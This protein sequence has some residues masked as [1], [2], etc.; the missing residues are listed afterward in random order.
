LRSVPAGNVK[1]SLGVSVGLA[2][3]AVVGAQS[4]F[5]NAEAQ[6]VDRARVAL[7]EDEKGLSADW[8]ANGGGELGLLR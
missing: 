5:D 2:P 4:V 7:S 3:A 1:R 6:R 8:A